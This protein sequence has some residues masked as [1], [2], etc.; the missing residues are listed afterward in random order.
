[1][2]AEGYRLNVPPRVVPLAGA[3]GRAP[4]EHSFFSVD[5]PNV[6]V[7]VV[8]RA[9]RDDALIVRLYEAHNT[10]GPV[11]LATSLPVRQAWVA[12]LMEDPLQP[13]DVARG[14]IRLQVKP[15]E[16]VTLCLK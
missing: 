8:K 14:E 5:N 3:G 9:E 16:I 6:F 7:E 4:R 15:F 2:V 1:V 10:R 12:D 11:T 13:V